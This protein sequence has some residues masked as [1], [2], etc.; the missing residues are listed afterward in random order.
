MLPGL[1][2]VGVY[3]HDDGD[4]RF[5]SSLDG[6]LTFSAPVLIS[7]GT[8]NSSE[9]DIY[10]DTLGYVHFAWSQF[11]ED[12]EGYIDDYDIQYRRAYLDYY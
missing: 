12:L 9:P 6:G 1:I 8:G 10:A 7:D 4:I 5:L 2:L 3:A 11:K